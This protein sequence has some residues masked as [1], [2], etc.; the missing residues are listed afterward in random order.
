MPVPPTPV[1]HFVS[2]DLIGVGSPVSFWVSRVGGY[3]LTGSLL[4]ILREHFGTVGVHFAG[5]E[6]MQS[7]GP[8]VILGDCTVIAY[9]SNFNLKQNGDPNCIA[10]HG[11]LP[12]STS[13][14]NEVYDLRRNGN[15]EWFHENGNGDNVLVPSTTTAPLNGTI[16]AR[17]SG[18]NILFGAN[19]ARET[20]AFGLPA[21]DGSNGRLNVGGFGSS[22]APL[23][24]SE[25]VILE[26]VIYDRVLTDQEVADVE[27]EFSASYEGGK[28]TITPVDSWPTTL[29]TLQ[30]VFCDG[31]NVWAAGSDQVARYDLDGNQLELVTLSPGLTSWG[32]LHIKGGTLYLLRFSETQSQVYTADPNNLA[33]GVTPAS[34]LLTG[35]RNGL[36]E[37]GTGWRIGE[38]ASSPNPL[39][40]HDYDAAWTLQS[41]TVLA[42]SDEFGIQ[43]LTE[44]WTT[45]HG[46]H[47]Y[48]VEADGEITW[49]IQFPFDCQ[50][51]SLVGTDDLWIADRD[52]ALIRRYQVAEPSLP[53]SGV[54]F[55]ISAY[56][57]SASPISGSSGGS[58][59]A[60]S[61]PLGTATAEALA[62][63]L[64]VSPGPVSLAL[65]TATAE[66]TALPIPILAETSITLG[67]ATADAVAL[68]L[69]LAP[70]TDLALGTAQAD[71]TANPMGIVA[72]LA[73]NLGT[74]I[75]RAT[76]RPVGLATSSVF[77]LGTATASA[78]TRPL[79]I[80]IGAPPL[81]LKIATAE[82]TATAI[83]L[84]TGESTLDLGTA[85]A[86]AKA[87]PITLNT[88]TV[89]DLGTAT[90]EA[91]ALPLPLAPG[92]SA[93]ALGQAIASAKAAPM[94]L[95]RTITIGTATASART[96]PIG[97]A[98]SIQFV[99]GTATATARTRPMPLVVSGAAFTLGT[100]TAQATAAPLG[101]EQGLKLGTVTAD[102]V[103]TPLGITRSESFQ[104]AIATAVAEANALG[105]IQGGPVFTLGQ[106]VALAKA[107]PIRLQLSTAFERPILT[108]WRR[109]DPVLTQ[110]RLDQPVL[111]EW[112]ED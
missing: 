89:L 26:L 104:L 40:W 82:A 94:A 5:A 3:T 112:S 78:R 33:G 6:V 84:L 31:T 14:D 81:A 22:T 52:N 95:G 110:W 98:Q 11:M 70:T 83:G 92:E 38:T 63:P 102:A 60:V 16:S 97:L 90:A 25:S 7:T 9:V 106:A 103:A 35:G 36:H 29:P 12:E 85:T 59:G 50:G 41:T 66:A 109:D 8:I 15:L 101:I 13:A 86:S 69:V 43:G 47:L 65:G 107:A 39:Q 108:Q 75:A 2:S 24:Q 42:G 55:A 93:L 23:N 49:S 73:I 27:S 32:G 64:P 51:V 56:P 21:T 72:G 30:S 18:S 80:T 96:E 62:L 20:V 54:P 58:S 105:L 1:A 4:P 57:I 44:G 99:L 34:P 68:P 10:S 91:L 17:R 53:T 79:P 100:A 48:K 88:G 28:E 77:V 19:G 71:A 45:D 74:A 61:L 46:G 76:T 67:T 87:A 111:T 37:N